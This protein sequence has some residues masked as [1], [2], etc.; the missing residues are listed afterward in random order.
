GWVTQVDQF[1]YGHAARKATWLYVAGAVPPLLDWTPLPPDAEPAY[2][3]DGGGDVRRRRWNRALLSFYA[4]HTD[5]NDGRRRLGK[6]EA[7]AT[8]IPFRDLLLSI[9]RSAGQGRRAA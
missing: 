6:R 5:A 3:T 9:A 2:V 4:N 7:N 8:P 1:N